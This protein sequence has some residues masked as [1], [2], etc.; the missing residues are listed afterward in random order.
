MRMIEDEGL[1]ELTESLAA[2]SIPH[3]SL[4]ALFKHLEVLVAGERGNVTIV[5][6]N[7]P[8]KLNAIDGS[9][10]KE[11]GKVFS[12]L[13]RNGDDCRAVLLVGNGKSF[14][15]GI[16]VSDPNFLPAPLSSDVDLVRSGLAWL[17]KLQL[18]QDCFT[19]LETC[20]VPVVAA[21]HGVCLGAGIDL[22]SCAD[23]R[24]CTVDSIFGVREVALGL[25]A[26]VGTL[27]RLPKIVGNSSTVRELCFTGRNFTGLEAEH[28]GLVSRAVPTEQLVDVALEVCR[29]IA[30]HSP[31]AVQGTKTALLYARDHSVAD[32]LAQVAF[33]NALAL[34]GKDLPIAWKA[35]AAR[36][37][38]MFSSMPPHSKL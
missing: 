2:G 8:H 38:A 19:A 28:L 27:Q 12:I 11:I 5:A 4:N 22:I 31:V 36:G 34:Q 32:G 16:D 15:A 30:R 17:P 21:I 24:L 3:P 13:G 10:W 1:P 9:L 29:N 35:N 23:V 37:R 6:L 33:Y 26:D 25:A 20:P 18:M 7:R 14:C